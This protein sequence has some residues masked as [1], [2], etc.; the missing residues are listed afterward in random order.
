MAALKTLKAKEELETLEELDFQYQ[1]ETRLVKVAE[2]LYV[3]QNF[4]DDHN[5]YA[6]EAGKKRYWG[7]T[8]V[9]SVVA[10]PNLI[11]WASNVN[12]ETIKAK[13]EIV[14]LKEGELT[15]YKVS[16][17]LLEEA[18]VAHAKKKEKA[19][20]DGTN[21]HSE[22]EKLIKVSMQVNNG[23]LEAYMVNDALPTQV[24]EF[25]QWAIV[26]DVKFLASEQRLC[27]KKLFV[28]GTADFIAEIG[29][30]LFI[31]DIKTNNSGIYPEHFW[32]ATAYAFMAREMGLYSDFKGV[33]IVNVP[34]R[35]GITVKENYDLKGNFQA[36]K[37]CL[38]LHKFLN[39][40]KTK[41]KK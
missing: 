24:K 27:S 39:S 4:E 22:I 36:F 23:K 13:A 21:V 5:Y 18:R 33:V 31:G 9:L 32:Q 20:E 37:A 41:K 8:T 10:K 26:N 15:Y 19:G 1:E 12:T 29:G 6:D 11:A 40:Q 7:I 3:P 38:T 35:G 30:R 2:N 17:E 25:V 34:K 16:P 28:A 14:S